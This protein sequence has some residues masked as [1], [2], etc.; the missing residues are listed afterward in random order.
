MNWSFGHL[1]EGIT[2]PSLI[3]LL[4]FPSPI[5][6]F[7]APCKV[8]ASLNIMQMQIKTPIS[9]LLLEKWDNKCFQGYDEKGNFIL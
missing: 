3:K 4:Q 7:P 6:S 5:R 9:Y 8:L 2:S 1:L